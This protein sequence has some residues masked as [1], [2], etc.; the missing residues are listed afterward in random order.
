[1]QNI[2]NVKGSGKRE[3]VI[4]LIGI[5]GP[6]GAGK[7]CVAQVFARRGFA[8]IDADRIAREI[9]M[10]GQPA[11]AA[12]TDAFGKDILLPDGSLDRR[13]LAQRAFS[14]EQ[15][16]KTLNEITHKEIC[17]RMKALA[18]G[19][20]NSGRNC[21]FDAPLLIEAGLTDIC[22]A[23]VA[24]I[25][26]AE[27]RTKRL[28]Q[29]DGIT[30]QEVPEEMLHGCILRTRRNGDRIRPFGMNGSK[31]LQDYFVDR[32]VDEPVR[33]RIPLICRGS[34][35]LMAAGVGTGNI[36]EWKRENRNIRIVWKGKMPWRPEER[37]CRTNES[38]F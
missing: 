38:E 20:M 32:K 28:M 37:L 26:S 27:E 36:P 15:G 5:T 2:I 14:S 31:K 11:L 10:P 4:V 22:N 35:V 16:T 33:S 9:V 8:V 13:L 21:L 12:L 18:D 29:R 23:C 30:E 7:G 24:V 25:A 17:K 19:Y 3:V 6:S 34:E 1:M